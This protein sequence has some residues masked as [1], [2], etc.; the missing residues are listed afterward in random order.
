MFLEPHLHPRI[1]N[2]F[3]LRNA[4]YSITFS[5]GLFLFVIQREHF[6]PCELVDAVLKSRDAC[7]ADQKMWEHA[8]P[9]APENI[10]SNSNLPVMITNAISRHL[11]YQNV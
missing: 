10:Q 6:I 11:L 7:C 8:G 4:K 1:I 3:V 5:H 2:G 9:F